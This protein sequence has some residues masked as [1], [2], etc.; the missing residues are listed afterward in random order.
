L[1]TP[2]EIV[3]NGLPEQF[4]AKNYDRDLR[5]KDKF[6]ILMVGRLAKEKRHTL[7]MEAIKQS[8]FKDNIQLFVTGDGAL[9]DE[10][11]A[12]G[13]TLPNPAIFEYV[14]QEKLI[15]LFNTADLF[16]H[17]SDIELEGMAVLEAIGCGLPALISDSKQSASAQFALNDEFLFKAGDLPSLHE[18]MD[19]WIENESGLKAAKSEYLAKA[20]NYAFGAG[21]EAA[22]THYQ[23]LIDSK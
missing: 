14:T 18:K 13:N 2:V 15:E 3:S 12:L 21:V 17:A 23:S 11:I 7:V 10:L 19:G 22:R 5:L 6:V 4:T 8:K 1:K 20:Q 16:I 9:K